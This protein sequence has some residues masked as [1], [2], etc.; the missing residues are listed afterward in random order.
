LLDYVETQ[1]GPGGAFDEFVNVDQTAVIGHSYGGYTSLAA[2][3]ARIDTAGLEATCAEAR[4]AGDP[5]VWLC[6][7]LTPHISEMAELAGFDTVPEGLWPSWSDLRV[8]AI[9]SMA[10][11]AYQFGQAGLAEISVPVMA[12]GGTLDTDTPYQWGTHPTY[13]YVSSTR[14]VRI[15]LEGAEHM[16]FTGTCGS[17][18]RLAE[19]AF[20]EFCSDVAW[21]RDH[22]HNLVNHFVTAFLLAELEQDSRAASVLAPQGIEFPGMIYEAQGY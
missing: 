2:A 21:D 19:L 17:T 4:A 15:T 6:D 9:V 3:G 1:T 18:S 22:A 16:V 5:N 20:G 11:D 14:K 13:E 7:M 8:D 10:G 12:I